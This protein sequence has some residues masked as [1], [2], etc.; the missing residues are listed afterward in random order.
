MLLYGWPVQ[1]FDGESLLVAPQ[2]PASTLTVPLTPRR[3]TP[4][5][6]LMKVLVGS[7]TSSIYHVYELDLEMPKFA[8]YAAED[9]PPPGGIPV[10]HV[11]FELQ[12][13]VS[14]IASWLEARFGM[15]AAL[16]A[17]GDARRSS[18]STSSG[19][20][21]E[22]QQLTVHFTC[23]RTKQPLAVRAAAGPNGGLMVWLHC[24][25]MALAG[26]MLQVRCSLV[27]SHGAPCLLCC[28]TCR[29]PVQHMAAVRMFPDSHMGKSA[30][31]YR[32]TVTLPA[33]IVWHFASN[34]H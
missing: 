16:A 4:V 22:Q 26:E 1:V 5:L 32:S 24:D 13:P 19:G 15:R 25:S 6:L 7:R 2:Q 21:R 34:A 20:G 31:M 3:D 27:A 10:S 18:T 14:R 30:R 23:L 33:L 28:H 8:A 11:C 12:H 17:S 9:R 29:N